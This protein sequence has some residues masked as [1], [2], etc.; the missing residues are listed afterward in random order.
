[1]TII[2]GR[3]IAGIF[4]IFPWK[5][6]WGVGLPQPT[7]WQRWA[8][9]TLLEFA[10]L[11]EKKVREKFTKPGVEI[12]QELRGEIGLSRDDGRKK[13]LCLDQQNKNIRRRRL[14][15]PNIFLA[16]LMR[17]M[18]SACIKARRYSLAPNKIVVFLRKTISAQSAVR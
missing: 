1:V 8:F 13:L 10:Q 16:H 6:S 9:A 2:K 11:P 3:D 4:A 5:K 12:W 18:E 7:I 15:M 14:P 17:N